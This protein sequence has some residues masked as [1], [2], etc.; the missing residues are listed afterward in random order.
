MSN[1]M[2]HSTETS[3]EIHHVF[4]N[5]REFVPTKYSLIVG[6]IDVATIFFSH[7]RVRIDKVMKTFLRIR[8]LVHSRVN[9]PRKPL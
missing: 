8:I 9:F 3:E 4:V 5:F 7:V 1:E 2:M 6:K